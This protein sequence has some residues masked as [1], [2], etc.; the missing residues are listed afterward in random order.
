MPNTK[1]IFR[2]LINELKAPSKREVTVTSP[3]SE[4]QDTAIHHHYW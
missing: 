2:K 4:E 1:L 3:V